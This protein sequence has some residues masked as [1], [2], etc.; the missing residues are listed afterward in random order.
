MDTCCGCPNRSI[1]VV[2]VPDRTGLK[3]GPKL[4]QNR[5]T[6]LDRQNSAGRVAFEEGASLLSFAEPRY[7]WLGPA[8]FRADTSAADSARSK[9]FASSTVPFR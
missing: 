6:L 1:N 4:V 5:Q 3:S 9:I 2:P 7:Y 8:V